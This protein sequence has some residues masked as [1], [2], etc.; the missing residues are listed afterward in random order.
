V[1]RDRPGIIAVGGFGS[2]A[3]KTTL[4]CE[5]LRAVPSAE[6]IKTTR[7][8]YRS[9]GKD[10]HA[11]CVSPL[12][13]A[14]PLVRTGRTQTYVA[15]KDTGRYWEAGAS[16]VHWV[17]ATDEQVEEGFRRALG[18]VASP[19]VVVEG[20]SFLKYFSADFVV[21]VASADAPKMKT[22]A[23][24]VVGRASAFYLTSAAG[25]VGEEGMARFVESLRR[26]GHAAM[27]ERAPVYTRRTLAELLGRVSETLGAETRGQSA[28]GS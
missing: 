24:Q 18:R 5:L 14:E 9:C 1:R 16:N 4:V 8:H 12:L 7:G 22:T 19:L 25:E 13:G 26:S 11:C 3:G 10:P 27:L 21:M 6:A 17:I 23:R 2:D 28:E 20:N 15:G